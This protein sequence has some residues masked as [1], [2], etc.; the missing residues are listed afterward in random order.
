MRPRG[1]RG[2]VR[3][4]LGDV[5]CALDRR[6]RIAQFVG[7]HRQEFVHLALAALQLVHLAPY[8]KVAG[9][10]GESA[11]PMPVVVYRCYDD[12]GP[13]Y[14]PILAN[15]PAFVF[16]AAL[17][18][19]DSQLMV[20]PL[21]SG[22]LGRVEHREMPPDDF[23]FRITL[24]VLGTGV[25]GDHMALRI[26]QEDRVIANIFDQQPEHLVAAEFRLRLAIVR[27]RPASRIPGKRCSRRRS[28][29]SCL[30][31]SARAHRASSCRLSRTS[32]NSSHPPFPCVRAGCSCR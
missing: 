15:P 5:E 17:L 8:R 3:L 7:E 20:R 18:A 9:D 21:A 22:R 10:L 25:P 1:R 4:A 13:E 11:Q 32:T 2:I 6:Q 23:G 29:P 16:E 14:G 27:H 12:V 31:K 28:G 19:R 30:R 24:D 26:E